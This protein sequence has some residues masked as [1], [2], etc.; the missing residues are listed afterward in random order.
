MNQLLLTAI[1]AACCGLPGIAPAQHEL[2]L[3]AAVGAPPAP[4]R[5]ADVSAVKDRLRSLGYVWVPTGDQMDTLTIHTIRLFQSIVQ[6]RETVGGD[7]AD[8]VVNVNGPT[9]AWLQ[10]A[11]S[12][13]WRLMPAR[14]EGFENYELVEQVQDDHDH[15]VH[16]LAETLIG[17]GAHYQTNYRAAHPRAAP[18]VVNDAS[19]DVG[20]D[21]PDHLGHETGSMV[22]LRLPRTDGRAGGITVDSPEYDRAAARAMLV[23]LHQQPLF[24]R[25]RLN[26]RVLAAET[27]TVAGQRRP[28]CIPDRQGRVHDNHIHVD[29]KP[30]RGPAPN[31]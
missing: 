2:P 29:I 14:G 16:W 6:N 24:E 12:P 26:D 10:H 9:H 18:I 22:D 20:R 1:A 27:V 28:L 19:R 5:P 8:G 23:A 17:A 15:G 21:T 31:E 30:P 13:K 7:G 25:A 3:S 4:N 11:D